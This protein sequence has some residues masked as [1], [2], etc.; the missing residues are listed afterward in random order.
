MDTDDL[1]PP[2]KLE[3]IVMDEMSIE[4]LEEHIASLEAEIERAREKIATKK[5]AR[6]AALSVFKV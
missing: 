3:P 2:P 6:G 5:A 4:A 1:A